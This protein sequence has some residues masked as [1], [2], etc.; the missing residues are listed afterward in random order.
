MGRGV[1]RGDFQLAAAQE[2]DDHGRDSPGVDGHDPYDGF[3]FGDAY[4]LRVGLDKT[5]TFKHEDVAA[6]MRLQLSGNQK[7]VARA[8]ETYNHNERERLSDCY[9]GGAVA[10]LAEGGILNVGALVAMVELF[11]DG[12]AEYPLP[13]SVDEDNFTATVA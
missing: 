5:V 6:E 4:Q 9:L 10:V 12:L 7:G 1:L 13:F 2:G 11:H 3:A 8:A